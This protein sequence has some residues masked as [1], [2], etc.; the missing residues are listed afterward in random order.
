MAG[1]DEAEETS[2]NGSGSPYW[3]IGIWRRVMDDAEAIR[4]RRGLHRSISEYVHEAIREKN[5]REREDE[6]RERALEQAQAKGPIA[7]LESRGIGY[8]AEPGEKPRKAGK[9]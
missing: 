1:G 5:Q 9:R 2:P 7:E 4:K 3:K 6:M 8:R